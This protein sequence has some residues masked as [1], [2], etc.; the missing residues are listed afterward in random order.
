MPDN[1]L[2][3][4]A[5]DFT[6]DHVL[7]HAVSLN[8]FRGN[9]VVVVFGGRDSAEQVAS[10]IGSL[11]RS[12]DPAQLPILSVSDLEPVPRPARIIAKTQLKKAFQEAV[13]DQTAVL[14][15]AGKPVPDDDTKGVTMLMDWTGESVRGFGLSGVDQRAV[16]VVVD[17]DG[18]IV[19]SAGGAGWADEITPLLASG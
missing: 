17:Q 9:T 11:R 8:E 10:G 14:E 2:P 16:G 19:G 15:A 5:P 12:F 7:G 1:Q 13:K 4:Q 18:G 3:A 6:L